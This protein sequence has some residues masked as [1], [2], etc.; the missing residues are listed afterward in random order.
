MKLGMMLGLAGLLTAAWAADLAITSFTS[1]GSLTWTNSVSTAT[2]RVEWAGTAQGPWQRFDA[3]TNLSSITAT[4]NL[5]TVQVPMF[6]RVV[7]LDAP[8][9]AGT[10]RYSGYEDGGGL[11]IT[12]R[13]T[14]SAQTNP[15]SGTWSLRQA[16]DAIG[17]IGPQV[18]EGQL[19]GILS[20]SQLGVDLNPGWA[21]NNV[22]LNGRLTGNAWTGSWSYS[23]FGGAI[24]GGPF[25]AEKVVDGGSP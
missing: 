21:D 11:V 25:T 18:G 19:R 24:N 7:W 1:D 15:V 8:Q 22:G 20:G 9:H 3:L 16:G 4:S 14:L 12:G 5:V 17:P 10:Y 2:Y 13:I 6:Y 23:T